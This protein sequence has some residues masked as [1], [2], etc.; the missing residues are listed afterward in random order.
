LGELGEADNCSG[1]LVQKD[2]NLKTLNAFCENI[3]AGYL[4]NKLLLAES[5]YILEAIAETERAGDF[6]HIQEVKDKNATRYLLWRKSAWLTSQEKLEKAR[7]SREAYNAVLEQRRETFLTLRKA[8]CVTMDFPLTSIEDPVVTKMAEKIIKNKT[9]T[10][11]ILFG[12]KLIDLP[13]LPDIHTVLDDN[14][15]KLYQ[16]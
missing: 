14:G 10:A 1:I 7:Q 15:R 6:W 3:L 2:M 8:I 5:N 16:L 9:A 4:D 12:V 11:E 13:E